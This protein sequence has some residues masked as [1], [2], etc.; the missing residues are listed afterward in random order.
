MKTK[1]D[2]IRV[3]HPKLT[4]DIASLITVKHQLKWLAEQESLIR[5]RILGLIQVEFPGVIVETKSGSARVIHG[6]NTRIDGHVLLEKGVAPDI[7]QAA[8]KTTPYVSLRVEETK[9][10]E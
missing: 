6:N 2:S 8:T 9:S 5:E 4:S 3:D 7:I 1:T 10:T